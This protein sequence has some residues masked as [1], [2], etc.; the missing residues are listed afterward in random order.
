MHTTIPPFLPLMG[1]GG[2]SPTANRIIGKNRGWVIG[3]QEIDQRSNYGEIYC[4][5]YTRRIETDRELTG[6]P[7]AKGQI[8]YRYW[9][10]AR[11]PVTN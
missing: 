1:G 7:L 5:I 9:P 2:L 11:V 8:L 3:D 6:S 4:T 10:V